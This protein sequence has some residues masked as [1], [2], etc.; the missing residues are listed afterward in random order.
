MRRITIIGA[1]QAG[2]QLGLGLLQQGYDVTIV[3]DRA[4]VDIRHGPAT[5]A[6]TLFGQA[7]ALEESLGQNAWRDAVAT[8]S[9]TVNIQTPAGLLPIRSM[10]QALAVD[11]RLKHAHWL[12]AFAEQGGQVMLEA[13]TV[14]DLERYAGAN[15]LVVVAAGAKQFSHLFEQDAERSPFDRPQRRLLQVYLS[16]VQPWYAPDHPQGKITLMP[17]AGE[18]FFFPFY[19]KNHE[20]AHIV[21]IE[22]VPGGP[23][24]CFRQVTTGN[25]A[26]AMTKAIL[27]EVVPADHDCVRNAVLTDENGWLQ[28]AITPTVR[29]PVGWLPSGA[30]VLG[31]GDVTILNDPVG[32]QGANNATKFAHLLLDRIVERG[33]RPFDAQWMG[34]VFEEFWR[35]SRYVN[36]LNAELLQPPAPHRVQILLAASRH[37]QIAHDFLNGFDHPPSLFPWFAEP[38]AAAGYLAHHGLAESMMA[39]V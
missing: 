35:Y 23:L 32:G 18:I 12:C 20:R 28:G 16:N 19:A 9:V 2:L 38:L 39:L 1:G 5:G 11:Q 4:P 8:E 33:D 26:L 15:D 29:K 22:A 36:A 14:S 10:F 13:A 30:A 21:L 24:D 3:S 17:G 7:I 27:A 37:P 34:A 25:A 31:I 6:A